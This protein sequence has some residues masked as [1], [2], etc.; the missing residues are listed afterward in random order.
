[1]IYGML[2]SQ[3]TIL[4]QIEGKILFYLVFSQDKK[5]WNDSWKMLQ[6]LKHYLLA[7]IPSLE[8]LGK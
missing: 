5:D 4:A 6:R 7:T 1:M 2:I 8:I 3:T